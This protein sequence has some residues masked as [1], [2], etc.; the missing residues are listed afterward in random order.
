VEEIQD[1]VEEELM[2]AG[3][4]QEARAYIL[5]REERRK[6]RER[7]LSMPVEAVSEYVFMTKYSR[8]IPE[9]RRRETYEEAVARSMDMHLE[10]FPQVAEEIRWAFDRVLDKKVLP[11]MRA[12]ENSTP[13]ITKLGWKKAGEI[14]KGD[15]LY[16]SQGKETRVLG[17]VSFHDKPLYKIAFSD[18]SEL[19]AC[20]EHLWIVSSLDDRIEGRTRVVD[21]EYLREHLKQGDRYNFVVWNPMPIEREDQELLIAPYILGLWLGDGYSNGHQY[22]SS[23]EDSHFIM[24]QFQKMGFETTPSNSSNVWTH[25]VKGLSSLL[26]EY[27]LINNKHIPIPYLMGSIEQRLQLLQGLMDSDG[28]VTPSGRCQFSNTN[29]RILEGVGEF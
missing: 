9:K 24:G 27:D 13:I 11:S 18:G 16:D 26:R 3:L 23:V 25:S 8:Y 19:M 5:K 7:R 10:R 21:T 2:E 17:V 14:K 28:C 1:L 22:S 4:Y 12:L 20:G 6:Y 29:F 15:V